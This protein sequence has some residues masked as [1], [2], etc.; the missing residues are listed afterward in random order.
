MRTTKKI[1]ALISAVLLLVQ[2]MPTGTPVVS[3]ATGLTLPF[4][5]DFQGSAWTV[6]ALAG[7]DDTGNTGDT[8]A[9]LAA[10]EALT[11]TLPDAYSGTVITKIST[12]SKR[13]TVELTKDDILDENQYLK[14]TRNAQNSYLGFTVGNFAPGTFADKFTFEFRYKNIVTQTN[15]RSVTPRI[16]FNIGKPDGDGSYEEIT[17][18][19]I[20][21]TKIRVYANGQNGSSSDIIKNLNTNADYVMSDDTWYTI[22]CTLN[23]CDGYMP[24]IVSIK[25]D[26]E[27]YWSSQAGSRRDL[28][29]TNPVY[30]AY[31]TTILPEYTYLRFAYNQSPAH[32]NLQSAA[33]IDDLK[34]YRDVAFDESDYIAM[35]FEDD[36]QDHTNFKAIASDKVTN[37]FVVNTW[38][39]MQTG[40]SM[41][42][43]PKAY[44]QSTMPPNNQTDKSTLELMSAT[45]EKYLKMTRGNT[46]NKQYLN[47]GPFAP[48][49]L[50]GNI[51][52]EIDLKL[53]GSATA[54]HPEIELQ[55]TTAAPTSSNNTSTPPEYLRLFRMQGNQLYASG[56][57]DASA[58]ASNSFTR[59]GGDLAKGNW[60]TIKGTY[61]YEG[62]EGGENGTN[63]L[64]LSCQDAGDP[65]AE[66][67]KATYFANHTE[68]TFEPEDLTYV[69]IYYYGGD[70][71]TSIS[72]DNIKLYTIESLKVQSSTPA[73]DAE[74]VAPAK[75]NQVAELI[76][77]Q[78]VDADTLDDGIVLTANDEDIEFTAAIDESDNT[79]VI[80][81]L[82]EGVYI[83]ASTTYK[84]TATD[85]L[86][87]A[88]PEIEVNTGVILSYTT[89]S[90]LGY[91]PVT[92]AFD[93][94][95][96]TVTANE[97]G[98][99]TVIAAIYDES[100]DSPQ[101]WGCNMGVFED[102]D[103]T[104]AI[105]LPG[106][107]NASNY[108]V[109]VFV[110]N[111]TGTIGPLYVSETITE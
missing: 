110:W 41:G 52:F 96:V 58:A 86:K 24:L 102:E 67:T 85:D 73:K 51:G 65:S 89:A 79:K 50:S 1:M 48:G 103:D 105:T 75:T 39:G 4:S 71:S 38:P 46:N 63:K 23:P 80:V 44:S 6:R 98:V 18:F 16:D 72:I 90:T 55:L 19:Q 20:D 101:L 15:N 54:Y 83:K 82:P 70:S 10:P 109:R 47:I 13:S 11:G 17:L 108:T 32:A 53:E 2:V 3:A 104:F 35:P 30:T 28:T 60:H 49:T 68:G 7:T 64:T 81:S 78:A 92:A 95:V 97:D 5:D 14:L 56:N 100:G 59:L 43:L 88:D 111:G 106:D 37:G 21:E 84:I 66:P 61:N 31:K 69:C 91:A 33:G 34:I 27:A 62:R 99:G 12:E 76:F 94:G 22:K 77:N 25:A 57:P 93:T 40:A 8:Y 45:E 36:F 87:A 74:D 9:N 42:D 29:S 107:Y 26:A